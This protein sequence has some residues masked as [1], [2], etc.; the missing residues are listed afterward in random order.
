[1]TIGCHAE[2]Q[3][4]IQPVE[5]EIINPGKEQLGELEFPTEPGT[6]WEYNVF[7]KDNKGK[8]YKVVDWVENT[9]LEKGVLI[10]NLSFHSLN[11]DKLEKHLLKKTFSTQNGLSLTR[12][13]AELVNKKDE[14]PLKI[15]HTPAAR[16]FPKILHKDYHETQT[17]RSQ[18]SFEDSTTIQDIKVINREDLTIKGIIYKDC[19]IITHTCLTKYETFQSKTSSKFWFKPGIG[20]VK[21]HYNDGETD[22]TWILKSFKKLNLDISSTLRHREPVLRVTL[23]RLNKT[24]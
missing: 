4:E 24:R 13:V 6:R 5:Y 12:V 1:M 22:T 9:S 11:G 18:S 8:I 19:V 15:T 10:R 16:V 7:I 23:A 20:I 21:F 2:I 17:I 3:E 14:N